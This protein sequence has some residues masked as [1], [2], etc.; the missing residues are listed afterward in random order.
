MRVYSHLQ[1]IRYVHALISRLMSIFPVEQPSSHVNSKHE[2]LDKIY[3]C[4]AK[5]RATSCVCAHLT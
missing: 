3:G 2:E 1:I 5:V 4:V